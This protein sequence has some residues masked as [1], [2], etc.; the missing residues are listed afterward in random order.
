MLAPSPRKQS[1]GHPWQELEK[2][3]TDVDLDGVKIR[4][5]SLEGLLLTKEGMRERDRA[6]ARVLRQVLGKPQ[7]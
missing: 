2:Y 1:D 4:V 7:Q 5:L 6:D 3:V